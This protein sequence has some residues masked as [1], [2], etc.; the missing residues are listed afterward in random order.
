MV[1]EQPIVSGLVVKEISKYFIVKLPKEV[2]MTN[3]IGLKQFE[4]R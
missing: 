4:K 1:R 2:N 3:I